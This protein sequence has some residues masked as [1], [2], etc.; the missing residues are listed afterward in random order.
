MKCR[1]SRLEPYG[2]LRRTRLNWTGSNAFKLDVYD[3]FHLLA[4]KRTGFCGL[5]KYVGIE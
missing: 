1:S 2:T 3:E 5:L 4:F